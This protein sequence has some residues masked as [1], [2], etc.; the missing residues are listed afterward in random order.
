MRANYLGDCGT[1]VAQSGEEGMAEL[2][3][4]QSIGRWGQGLVPINH[5]GHTL[6]S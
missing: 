1:F 3:D 5:V 4:M 2:R 6:L